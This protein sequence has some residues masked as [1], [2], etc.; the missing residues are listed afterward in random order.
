MGKWGSFFSIYAK[1][2]GQITV[3][4]FYLPSPPLLQNNWKCSCNTV[5][6]NVCV[7]NWITFMMILVSMNVMIII[8]VVAVMMTE[9]SRESVERKDHIWCTTVAPYDWRWN[10]NTVT[11]IFGWMNIRLFEFLYFVLCILFVL[12]YLQCISYKKDI[13]LETNNAWDYRAWGSGECQTQAFPQ[14]T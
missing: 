6:L 14:P 1:V 10:G 2:A 13:D 4:S 8:A 7:M 9:G 12:T 11:L 3:L 5:I